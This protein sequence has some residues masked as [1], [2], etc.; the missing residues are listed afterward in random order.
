MLNKRRVLVLSLAVIPAIGMTVAF[1]QPGGMRFSKGDRG[2]DSQ[3]GMRVRGPGNMDPNVIFSAISGGKDFLE[4]NAWIALSQQR[5][6]TAKEKI[7]A[8]LQQQGITNGRVTRDQFAVF[9][10]QVTSGAT[11]GSTSPGATNVPPQMDEARLRQRFD[12]LDL[13]KDGFLQPSEIRA[14]IDADPRNADRYGALMEDFDKYDKNKNGLIEY[15][16]FKDFFAARMQAR[17]D[18]N[19]GQRGQQNPDDFQPTKPEE[20]KQVVYRRLSD[21]PKDLPP[22]FV[23]VAHRN[24]GQIA[25]Y[26][27]KAANM[28]V[29]EF[30]KYD[31]NADGFITVEEVLSVERKK[32]PTDRRGA[33]GS[34]EAEQPVEE[35][36]L[37]LAGPGAASEEAITASLGSG[38]GSYPRGP[39]MGNFNRG[40]GNGPPNAGSFTRGGGDPRNGKGNPSGKG[41]KPGRGNGE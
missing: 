34:L 33:P 24:P 16:E 1:A 12:Q 32:A 26:E 15:D 3:G 22:W 35:K 6:P 36:M 11:P 10:R 2:G 37:V 40:R 19:S 23:Q 7:E 41:N 39:Q 9:W 25:L 14:A 27:W 31:R 38:D 21:L 13:N 18:Q 30:R 8:F 20:E 5:D 17:Q 4:V 28:Q 29:A